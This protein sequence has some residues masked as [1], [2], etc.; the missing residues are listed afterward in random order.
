MPT[1][2]CFK[3][4]HYFGFAEGSG[5]SDEKIN[6][7]ILFFSRFA[8]PLQQSMNSTLRDTA[9]FRWSNSGRLRLEHFFNDKNN[10]NREKR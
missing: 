1:Y 7:F 10:T 8:Q 5:T 6:P 4:F 3:L 9:E 2:F